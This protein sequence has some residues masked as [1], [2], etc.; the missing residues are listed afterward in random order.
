[1][2]TR[3]YTSHTLPLVPKT[4]VQ[5]PIQHLRN[6]TASVHRVIIGIKLNLREFILKSGA[7]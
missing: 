2:L 7:S 6:G 4:Q 3:I 5:S 1:M